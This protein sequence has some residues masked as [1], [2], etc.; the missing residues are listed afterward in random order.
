MKL[1]IK[2]AHAYLQAEK[3]SNLS[4]SLLR[5]PLVCNF[6]ERDGKIIDILTLFSWSNKLLRQWLQNVWKPERIN[7]P[8]A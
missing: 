2:R 8:S 3:L 7:S 6:N 5:T 1:A 4:Q